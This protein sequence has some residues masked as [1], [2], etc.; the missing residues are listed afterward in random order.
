[1]N[2]AVEYVLFVELTAWTVEYVYC[3]DCRI[4]FV[5]RTY[6]VDCIR[7]LGDESLY[8]RI[9]ADDNWE[10]FLCDEK[11]HKDLDLIM[12]REDWVQHL[13][14]FYQKPSLLHKVITIVTF[15]LTDLCRFNLGVCGVGGLL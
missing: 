8:H 6:C 13:M 15:I 14:K 10:C 5:C 9:E 12:I 7:M 11:P 4:C 2:W 1:M 3:V